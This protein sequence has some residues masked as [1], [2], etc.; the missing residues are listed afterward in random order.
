MSKL[1][2]NIVQDLLP[3]FVDSLVND[4]TAKEIKEHLAD[5]EDCAKLY[6]EMRNGE[7]F[8]QKEAKKEINYLKKIKNK[9]K[10]IIASILS[11]LM[12]LIIIAFGLYCFIGTNDNAY[13]VND[14]S[15]TNNLVSA[16]INLFSSSNSITKVYAKEKDGIVTISVKSSLFSFHKKGVTDFGFMADESISKVQTADGRVLWEYDEIIPQKINDIFN[17]KARYIGDNTAVLKLL[18]AININDTLKCK[19]Y[20]IQL[21]TDEKPYGLKIY[22]IDSYDEMF[23]AFTDESYE[24]K[25]KSIAFIVLACIE[26]A[27]FVQFEY[28]T[29]DGS[30]KTYKL[31]IDEA[32]DYLGIINKD[33]STVDYFF[34]I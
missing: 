11:A 12:I 9:N 20:S 3:S 22:D 25:I 23:S 31:T 33:E 14:I 30:E 28:T 18:S 24:Q 26:N 1:E 29:P 19:D 6:N 5:C 2:C 27:D 13:S 17:A 4:E 10:I 21:L 8:E 15:V 16:E 34:P 32:N 7:N